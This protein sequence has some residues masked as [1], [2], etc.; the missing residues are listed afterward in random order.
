MDLPLPPGDRYDGS[1]LSVGIEEL[2]PRDQQSL[3]ALYERLCLIHEQLG[4]AVR[5]VPAEAV[6]LSSSKA[7]ADFRYLVRTASSIGQ[8][9]SYPIRVRQVIHDIRGGSL[10]ALTGSL[11]LLGNKLLSENEL[12]QL[13]CYARDHLKIIRNCFPGIDVAAAERDR[14]PHLHSMDLIRQKW[15]T[16]RISINGSSKRVRFECSVDGAISNRCMEFAALDRVLYNLMNNAV[17]NGDGDSIGLTIFQANPGDSG[18]AR[19]A[20]QNHVSPEREAALLSLTHDDTNRLFQGGLSQRGSGLGLQICAEF[21]RHAVG[22]D[23]LR[24]A[25]ERQY[26][27]ARIVDGSFVVWFHWPRVPAKS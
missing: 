8:D 14:S 11:D 1:G 9:P 24:V 27:G 19:F 5:K 15:S 17:Q 26:I 7:L 2:H 21:V 6:D 18:L 22:L 4:S 23:S 25:V 13:F 20:V 3:A 12:T 10:L 16:E